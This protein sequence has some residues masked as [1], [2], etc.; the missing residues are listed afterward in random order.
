[1]NKPTLPGLR[2]L[3]Q[4][5]DLPTDDVQDLD[6]A[7]SLCI[8]NPDSPEAVIALQRFGDGLGLLR[9]L[10]VADEAKGQGLGTRLVQELEQFCK[11][12]GLTDLYLLTTTAEDFFDHLRYTRVDRVAV[13]AAIQASAEFSA[14]CPADAVVMHKALG[15]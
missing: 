10:A 5:N 14:I 2:A 12:Q 9:S 6:L 4:R 11:K 7:D 3:L 8:G 13:P 1:M 15:I